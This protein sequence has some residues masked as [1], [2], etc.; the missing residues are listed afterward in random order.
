MKPTLTLSRA[1]VLA[2]ATV[3]APL[4]GGAPQLRA[5]PAENEPRTILL[6]DDAAVLYRPGTKRVLRPL[7]RHPA[8]PLLLD[9]QPWEMTIAYCSVHHDREGGRYQ[10]WYQALA[11]LSPEATNVCYAESKD[12]LHW[13]RPTL[14]LF[15]FKESTANNIVLLGGESYGASVVFDPRDPDPSRRYKMARF[16]LPHGYDP[17]SAGLYVMFSPD[18][19]HWRRHPERLLLGSFGGA[20][21]PPP[22]RDDASYKGGMPLGLS[23]VVDVSYDPRLNKFVIFCKTWTDSPDGIAIWK[24]AVARTESSDFLHWSR[25]Q[26]MLAPDEFDGP[27]LEN[28][29][30]IQRGVKGQVHPGRRGIQI[31]GGPM[32]IRHGV[33]FS[34]LQMLDGETTGEM[35]IELAISRDGLDWSRPFRREPF[36]DVTHSRDKFDGG[37]IWSNATP[38]VL[39]D[40]IRFYYG[41]YSGLW[42][43]E[44]IRKPTGIGLATMP[45]DRF[46][47]ITPIDQIGQITLKPLN[48]RSFTRGITLNA[49]ASQGSIRV[50]VLTKDG[51]RLKGDVKGA[52]TPIY[53]KESCIPIRGDSLRHQVRWKNFNM[54]FEGL[55]P[56]EYQLRLHLERAT[57]Y[58]INI[59]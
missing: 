25:P 58:A 43:G 45:L 50:E 52:S 22:F 42:K 27:G 26:L 51:Y 39:D 17:K 19:I 35:P 5:Q 8:N 2:A 48:L 47:G 16:E 57:V 31:H 49:D 20:G 15:P 40:E 24:R 29:S 7:T 33:Y 1:A 14:G 44:L 53:A 18:G 55:P 34:L 28:R 36:L 21:E 3:L 13:H 32:F 30:P 11:S 23:D 37:S 56:S 4:P 10:L 6:V 38:V 46:A 59:K 9:D 12:G 41:A 54:S